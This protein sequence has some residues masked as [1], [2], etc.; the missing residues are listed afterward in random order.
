M[1]TLTQHFE[2]DTN[3]YKYITF[4]GTATLSLIASG[5]VADIEHYYDYD[6]LQSSKPT[7]EKQVYSSMDKVATYSPIYSIGRDS[8]K[9]KF[10]NIILFAN[11]II[12]NNE[13]VDREIAR[14]IDDNFMDLLA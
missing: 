10:E 11:D 8:E 2:E 14:I 1:N 4:L 5:N 12:Q 13:I 7:F 6:S 3:I 9:D